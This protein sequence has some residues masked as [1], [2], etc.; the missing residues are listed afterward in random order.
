ML[1][2]LTSQI[3]YRPRK[4]KWPHKVNH[5]KKEV[6]VYIASGW[7]TVMMAPRVVE[8]AYPGYKAILVKKDPN[9]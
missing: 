4:I 2:T 8:D 9:E 1:H 5:E 6:E 7:P 3:T